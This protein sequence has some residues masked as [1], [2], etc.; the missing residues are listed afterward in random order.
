MAINL[1]L[2]CRVRYRLLHV[3]EALPIVSLLVCLAVGGA[4]LLQDT[5]APSQWLCAMKVPTPTSF[6]ASHPPFLTFAGSLWMSHNVD[7]FAPSHANCSE[8]K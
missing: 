6:S 7:T 5:S 1:G 3:A 8:K 4:R 2:C